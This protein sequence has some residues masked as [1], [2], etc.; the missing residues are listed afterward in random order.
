VRG[1]RCSNSG[2]IKL[3]VDSFR[4]ITVPSMLGPTMG[5]GSFVLPSARAEPAA[6]LHHLCRRCTVMG[7]TAVTASRV[8]LASSPGKV[9]T[10]MNRQE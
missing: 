3:H 8:S 5:G 10:W 7:C 4:A 9:F 2:S 6:V 1:K